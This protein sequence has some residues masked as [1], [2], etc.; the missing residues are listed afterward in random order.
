[1]GESRVTPE[2]FRD[3]WTV[4]TRSES[5]ASHEHFLDL[6]KVLEV[7]T[8]GEADP[9]GTEYTFERKVT[10]PDGRLGRADVW[11]RGCFAWE[12]KG[13]KK[14]LVAAYSQ[15][16]EY[17]DALENPP[18][19]IV[20]DMKE[21]RVHTNFT[22]T[23]ALTKVFKLPDLLDPQVRRTLRWCFADPGRWRPTAT[24][25][26]VTTQAAATFGT[27]A[28]RLRSQGYEPRRVAHFLNKLVFCL[29]AEDIE[30]LPNRV[31]ADILEESL[32][33]PDGFAPMLT[34][35]FGAMCAKN[36]R[37]GTTAIPWFDGGL[38]DDDD[39]LPLGHLEIKDLAEAARLDWSAIEPA[40]FGTMFER[41]L[42]PEKRQQMASLF[43]AAQAETEKAQPGL[44]DRHQPDRGV[45]IHYTD[46][47]T[48]MKLIE[49]VVLRPLRAQWESVKEVVSERRSARDKAAND[50]ARTRAENEARDAYLRF[51]V[52][53]G[54]FRVLDPACGSGN[55]LH[56]A[57][58]HLK[59]F[60]LAVLDEARALGLPAD[61][62]RVGPEA[63]LG[64]EINPYAA[65]LARVTVWIGELQWQM[66]RGFG[67]SRTPILGQLSG[68]VCGDALFDSDG[69]ESRW[70]DADAIIGNPPFL[71]GK[72]QRSVLPEGYVDRLFS[73]FGD[74]VPR[75]AD[76][77]CY[78]F[79]KAGEM[80]GE[81]RAER[82]GLVATNSIR[83]GANRRLLDRLTECLVI[84][85]AWDDEAWIIDGAAVRVSLLSFC[86]T[87]LYSG[88]PALDGEPVEEVFTDLTAR[89]QASGVDLTQARRLE[90]N[91]GVAF[92]GD[93][94]GGKFDVPGALARQWLQLPLNPN[95]RPNSDVLKPWVNGLDVTRRPRDMWIVDFG[96]QMSEK[97][98]A[99]YEA[100]HLHVDKHVRLDRTATRER[101]GRTWWRHIRPRPE[102]WASIADLSRYIAT[103][104]VAKHRVFVWLPISIC[105]DHQLIVVA[106]EDDVTFGI[107]HSR[108]HEI[109]ALRL[110][111]SLEDRPR[112]TPST[113][114]E[115]FPFPE[116][117][118]PNIAATGYDDDPRAKPIAA[119]AK[120]LNELRENWLNPADLVKCEPE[121]A[122]GYPDRILPKGEKAAKELKKRT[123]TNL[124]NER[125]RWLDGAHRELD[126]AVAAAYGWPADLDDDEV[127]RRLLD[128]N[129]ARS[130]DQ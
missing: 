59:D 98:S 33:R 8:P 17:A 55:F 22:N 20:S 36:G 19:L 100:P 9:H 79:R 110:G 62:Q 50:A 7:P 13:D 99:L 114:F 61:D 93:T 103:P 94:K 87:E 66:R 72:K 32:K 71:G 56:L 127:L 106:R 48:I 58:S 74:R 49:P 23:V 41:G 89:R 107:V 123:L 10:K 28:H 64:I 69:T 44:F 122:P 76:F 85:D 108:F 38:F 128:L 1:M 70:P 67:V 121:V 83:G 25:E 12:Y 96:W 112:Y 120:R 40:I 68:I 34:D 129:L 26:A 16:K 75:E 90:E 113:T 53:L 6:C 73:T 51:R 88:S 65:E 39:V 57:L 11:K 5:S 46:P 84:Y 104:T 3:K 126:E 37:F 125:P 52:R 81:G 27:I 95:G 29:F 117:L 116:G 4:S 97:E 109:W 130:G 77:V 42:D 63:V 102:M 115:T 92:M 80:V 31:F 118:S 18:L 43:D 35:L 60:D 47:Q 111:T 86:R 54:A 14:N 30:L 45:G 91:L 101:A 119:A 24:R 124:Y 78:W 82:F 105:P 21:I 15:L 2:E